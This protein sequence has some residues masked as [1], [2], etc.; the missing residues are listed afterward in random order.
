METKHN[1][2][3]VSIDKLVFLAAQPERKQRVRFMH[4]LFLLFV[5][6]AVDTLNL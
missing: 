2:H 6:A 4:G 5:A 1:A 3:I